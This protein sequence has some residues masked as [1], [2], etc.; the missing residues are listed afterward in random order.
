M[1][2]CYMFAFNDAIFNLCSLSLMIKLR[3]M[4]HLLCICFNKL[5]IIA[6]PI[7]YKMKD[8][9]INECKYLVEHTFSTWGNW[10][11]WKTKHVMYGQYHAGDAKNYAEKLCNAWIITDG[12]L[13]W[14]IY[15]G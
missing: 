1:F 6:F 10:R 3:T 5:Y 2:I 15:V 7:N 14:S 8:I 4:R 11:K 9:Q 13:N 12:K